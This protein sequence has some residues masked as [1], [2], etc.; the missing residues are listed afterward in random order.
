MGYNRWPHHC[1]QQWLHPVWRVRCISACA[2][3]VWKVDPV[4]GSVQ[5]SAKNSNQSTKT[6]N[7]QVIV[8]LEIH[9]Q[10][11]VP[12]K[13]F[14]P[15]RVSSNYHH[16]NNCPPNT[17]VHPFDVAV[18]GV[19]P[20]LSKAAVRAGVIAAAALNCAVIYPTSR[21]ER[22]HYSY[23]DLAHGYQIT[24]QRWPLAADGMIA[25]SIAVSKHQTKQ[26]QCR[27]NRIQLEQDTGKTVSVSSTTSTTPADATTTTVS[28]S[29]VDFNRAG[30]ALVEIVTEPDLRSSAEAASAVRTVQQILQHTG[31]CLGKMEAGQFRVDCNVNLVPITEEEI[32]SS[33][34]ENGASSVSPSSSSSSQQSLLRKSPR[35]EVKNLNS[36]KQVQDCIQ[37]EAIRQAELL[38]WRGDNG[39]TMPLFMET[40]TWN[41]ATGETELIRRKDGEEDYRFLPE[42]DIPPVVLNERILGVSTVQEFIEQNL[43]ELPAAA[44][45]RLVTDYGLSEYQAHVI[46]SGDSTAITFFDAAMKVAYYSADAN[47][48]DDP[49]QRA[50]AATVTANLLCNELFALVKEHHQAV[51]GIM[52]DHDNDDSCSLDVSKVSAKQLGEVVHL[53][54]EGRVSSTMAKNLLAVLYTECETGASPRKVAADRGFELITDF[55][56]L[57]ELCHKVIREHPD[58][59]HVYQKGGKFV[60]KMQKLFTGKVMAASRGN[61]HPERLREVLL[62]CLEGAAAAAAK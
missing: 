39:E 13:L 16:N 32:V 44:M 4:T 6:V 34:T 31:T 49:K 41:A 14:S 47:V 46:V 20:V 8:G 52:A 59:L 17:A 11:N 25:C 30:M 1:L 22:K 56:A 36:I 9:A 43:P 37:Y 29:R 5:S 2:T 48:N 45:Q 19:L 21:F 62:E 15:A 12:T 58:E 60:T 51:D 26:I 18:P 23:A 24:Q 55:D 10:L 7:Y 61:A 33:T 53:V 54:Q 3:T 38:Q 50:F 42:P 28:S 35:V 40:R 27:V 57:R